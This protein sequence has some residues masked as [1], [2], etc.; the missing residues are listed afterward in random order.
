MATVICQQ[1]DDEHEATYSHEG[2][3]NEGPIYA[4]V[5]DKDNLT[6]YYTTE[7]VKL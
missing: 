5:C 6:D 1:C 3:F 2:Q 4:V 7:V